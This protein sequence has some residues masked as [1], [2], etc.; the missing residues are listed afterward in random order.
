MIQIAESVTSIDLTDLR[1]PYLARRVRK[2]LLRASVGECLE[3]VCADPLA[4]VDSPP[5]NATQGHEL[6]AK[7]ESHHDNRDRLCR[8]P[9]LWLGLGFEQWVGDLR[10]LK[11]KRCRTL[12][13]LGLKSKTNRAR[14]SD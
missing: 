2:A 11:W 6:V 13:D 10:N 5:L 14:S 12:F 8:L 7:T 1:C 9:P 4:A 3:F